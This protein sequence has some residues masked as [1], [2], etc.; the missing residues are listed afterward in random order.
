MFRQNQKH[1]QVTLF[2]TLQQLPGGVSKMLDE[3]WAPAFRRLIFEQIDE[4]RYAGLY[5]LLKS[6][7]NFPVNIWVGL[8][9]IKGLFDY[10]DQE[11]LEQ[12]HFNLLTAYALGQQNL[13][14]VTLCE[15]TLYYNRERLLEYEAKTG[16]NLLEEE[17]KGITDGAI[18]QLH[19]DT[20]T[21]RMDSSFVG[22]FI[23][24]MSR[25]ELVVKVLQNLY[26]DLPE[27]ERG[28]WAARLAPYVEDEAEHIS[29]HL[30][31]AEIEEHLKEVGT[32][33][34]EIHEAYAYDEVVSAL[35]SYQH[36][37][38]VLQEQYAIVIEGER[39]AIEVRPAKE[40]SASSLQNPADDE[41][42]FR[43]KNGEGHKGYLFN[44]AETC[45]PRNPVQL[46]T[47]VSTHQNI[48]PDD[49]ILAKRLSEI[50]ERTGVEEMIVDAN[51]SGERSETVCREEGVSIVPTEVKGRRMTEGRISLTDFQFDGAAIVSCPVG[52]SPLEQIDKE[53]KDRHVVHFARQQCGY[54]P[55]V[56]V[57]PVCRRERFYSLLFSNRQALLAQ[58][59]QQ[60]SKEE[61]RRKC[62]L[63][64]ALEGTVSQFK[65]RTHNGKLRIRG[66]KKVRNSL[67]LIA[68]AINF[69]R[70]WAYSLRNALGHG[71]ASALGRLL[72]LSSPEIW[73]KSQLAW[74][75]MIT[76]PRLYA[77]A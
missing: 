7:P 28:R 36:V 42:T 65:R 9:I 3:S 37:G 43:R 54:C 23:K 45:S 4:R 71:C 53:G 47:D 68:I 69:G 5:S 18:A 52:Y 15:R 10:T 61:Y 62:R 60:L 17:F 24:Q 55:Q 44:I 33:L 46:L 56:A 8:E 73:R 12:F 59:R 22:S 38:R 11:L 21:Q 58:R 70:V 19:L 66:L 76:K 64:P 67:I 32:L 29:Y 2:G 39:S 20:E 51:Y 34:F 14:E 1:C 41:T 25:L 75:S 74:I 77:L 72:S 40:I 30:K 13:G 49:V 48:T 50:K 26:S 16:R 6:R 63:R 57:C 35:T 31:R 27:A